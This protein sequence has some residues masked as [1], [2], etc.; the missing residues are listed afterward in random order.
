M[1]LHRINAAIPLD[2]SSSMRG[3]V[4][5][6]TPEH[7]QLAPVQLVEPVPAL[8][9]LRRVL[10]PRD[11]RALIR[12]SSATSASTALGHDAIDSAAPARGA[13]GLRSAK[14]EQ[15]ADARWRA[16]NID[17][18]SELTTRQVVAQLLQCISQNPNE[19]RRYSATR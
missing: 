7:G 8:G 3:L 6:S 11:E 1:L 17:R 12:V 13:R 18:R 14:L 4:S 15:T 10:A 2:A 16:E 5:D 19:V 9:A